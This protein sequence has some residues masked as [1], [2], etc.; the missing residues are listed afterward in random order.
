MFKRTDSS[1]DWVFL[2]T[3][4]NTFNV[5]TSALF[6]NSSSSET[7]NGFYDSDCVSNGFKIR[8]TNAVVNASGGTYIYMAF[9]ESPFKYANAR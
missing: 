9:A 6:P 5:M 7:S 4:R 1:N 2:D 8:A 3:A